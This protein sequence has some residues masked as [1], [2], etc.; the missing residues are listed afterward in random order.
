MI[1]GKNAG[2]ITSVCYS[3]K[4]G[5]NIALGY[6][7]YDYLANGTELKVGETTATV[8]DLPFIGN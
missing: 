8:R 6:V 2:K 5:K 1:E 4:L 3:P 7:R